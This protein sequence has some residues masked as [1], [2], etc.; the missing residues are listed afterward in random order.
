MGGLRP[1]K[2][3]QWVKKYRTRVMGGLYADNRSLTDPKGFSDKY[4]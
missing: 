3:L 2:Y 1:P 4:F